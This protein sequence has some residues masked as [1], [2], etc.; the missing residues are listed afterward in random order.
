MLGRLWVWLTEERGKYGVSAAHLM[1]VPHGAAEAAQDLGSNGLAPGL[2]PVPA[3]GLLIPVPLWE[4]PSPLLS[5]FPNVENKSN[6]NAI[7]QVG[8]APASILRST[9]WRRQ[10][11][12]VLHM[13]QLSLQEVI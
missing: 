1:A 2:T 8:K 4:V 13:K 9:L 3:I 7:S 5:S 10:Y 11:P 12:R 6:D